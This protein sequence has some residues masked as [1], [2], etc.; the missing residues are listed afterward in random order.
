MGTHPF[1]LA[2][3][4]LLELAALLSVGIWGYKQSDNWLRFILMLV[5]PILLAV[6]WGTFAVPDD[7]SRSGAAPV[8]VPGALRLVLE[9][10]FFSFASWCLYNIGATKWCWVMVVVV[11][12]HYLVSYDRIIWLFNH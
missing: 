3:R 7:P 2:I 1:N 5:L 4:F 6:L 12:L 8:P 11:S 10:A 9:L